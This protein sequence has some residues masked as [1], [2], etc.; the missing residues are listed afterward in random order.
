MV[1]TFNPITSTPQGRE[2]ELEDWDKSMSNDLINLA[3][4][5]KHPL[6]PKRKGSG[7]FPDFTNHNL[8]TCWGGE[9][10]VLPYTPRNRSS[11]TQDTSRPHSTILLH[12][13]FFCILVISLMINWWTYANIS[14]RRELWKPPIYSQLV[15]STNNTPDLQVASKGVRA[16]SCGT[17]PWPYRIWHYLQVESV[18]LE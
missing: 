12:Q 8:C 1:G 3:S 7:E 10:C 16:Q 4:V 17:E 14:P 15:R 9:G 5:M 13:A 18:R 2:E 11:W 6:K